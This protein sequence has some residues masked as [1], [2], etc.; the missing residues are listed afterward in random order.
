[1]SQ[2]RLYVTAARDNDGK[3]IVTLGLCAALRQT[4]PT[5]GFVKPFGLTEFTH[6]G[7]RLDADAVLMHSALSPNVGLQDMSPVTIDRASAREF[8]ALPKDAREKRKQELLAA[9]D[10]A[11]SRA[12]EG[13][14]LVVIEGTGSPF[15]GHVYGLSN[16]DLAARLHSPV[17]IVASGGVGQPLDEIA[18][19]V[20]LYRRRNVPVIGVVINKVYPHEVELWQT[21]GKEELKG[22]GLELFGMI[23][24]DE[25]LR[26]P[27]VLH[28]ARRI[29]AEVLAGDDLQAPVEKVVLASQHG[30]EALLERLV[31]R[32]LVVASS[33][34]SDMLL[35][36]ANHHE[37]VERLAG[38]ILCGKAPHKG[39]LALARKA[40]LPILVVEAET[41]AIASTIERMPVKIEPGDKGKI[42][43]AC[44]LVRDK[45]D[46]P[47][48]LYALERA[49]P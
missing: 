6:A 38:V 26:A 43:R 13:K 7:M 48:I 35:A 19:D 22:L 29:G 21:F 33:D 36:A 34:R 24:T 47:G 37:N 17:L 39:V 25:V 12:R 31:P 20:E 27:T 16:V 1:M 32:A 23:P 3:T 8:M 46:L 15:V 28:V 30:A 45:V 4:T 11:F 40:G 41:Y 9:V 42:E 2:K 5:F 10:G 44:S 14:E 18:M 49:K